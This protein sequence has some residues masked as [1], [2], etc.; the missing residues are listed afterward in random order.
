M[1]PVVF[2]SPARNGKI[3]V[4]EELAMRMYLLFVPALSGAS[5][6][7][8]FSAL[9]LVCSV[10]CDEAERQVGHELRNWFCEAVHAAPKN[11]HFQV[12]PE[13]LAQVLKDSEG[14]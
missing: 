9:A 13:S 6:A 10:A 4:N 7:E 14:S 5:L 12:V 3:V 1:T 11:H 8:V 2:D